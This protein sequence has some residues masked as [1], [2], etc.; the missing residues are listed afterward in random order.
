MCMIMQRVGSSHAVDSERGLRMKYNQKG[1]P[2]IVFVAYV[3]DS[4]LS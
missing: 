3:E 4:S 1:S 2:S